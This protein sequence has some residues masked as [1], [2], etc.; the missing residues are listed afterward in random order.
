[1]G[2]AAAQPAM[3]LRGASWRPVILGVAGTIVLSFAVTQLGIEPEGVKQALELV[4]QPGELVKSLV[5]LALLAP[6]V[7]E[8]IFRG[9]IYGWVSGRWGTITGWI[10]SSLAFA[11]AHYEPAHILL[12]LP[13]GVL[14]GWLRR[15]TD[16]ILPSLVAHIVNNGFAVIAGAFFDS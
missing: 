6:L 9:L 10:V 13:L 7:E 15:R 14:F 8:L 3:G 11:A 2:W 12:V 16:S 4:R 1:L 5:V